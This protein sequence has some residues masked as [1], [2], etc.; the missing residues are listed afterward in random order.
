MEIWIRPNGQT[1]TPF[2]KRGGSESSRDSEQ[3]G[4]LGSLSATDVR[5]LYGFDSH[6]YRNRFHVFFIRGNFVFFLISCVLLFHGRSSKTCLTTDS[7]CLSFC[8]LDGL[9]F[10]NF[11]TLLI[12]KDIFNPHYVLFLVILILFSVILIFITQKMAKYP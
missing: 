7:V 5:R 3:D 2:N 1:A 12:F 9:V 10:S 6:V 11:I 8:H 4:E